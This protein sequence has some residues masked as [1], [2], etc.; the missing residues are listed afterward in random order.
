MKNILVLTPIYPAKD[1]PKG[2]TPVVHYFT[3]EWAKM[4]Y[5]VVVIHYNVN[6]PEVIY[7]IAKPFAKQ[8]SSFF[9]SQI[10][11]NKTLQKDY[12]IDDVK[13]KRIPLIKYWPHTRYS[14]SQIDKA[15]KATIKYCKD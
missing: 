12:I 10:V 2:S 6:F 3:K 13:V 5:N 7:R 15:Y 9:G 8:L 14:K 1:I 11:T 4:G